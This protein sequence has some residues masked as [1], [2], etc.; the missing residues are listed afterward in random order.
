MKK[1]LREQVKQKYGNKCSYCGQVL[2]DKWQVDHATP[3]THWIWIQRSTTAKADDIE[4]LVPACR[5]CNHY[6]R[7]QPVESSG[8]WIGYREYMKSF[9]KRL[10]KLPKNTQVPSTQRRKEYMWC[11]ANKYG[12]TP[13]KPFSGVFHMDQY[14]ALT[15][16]NPAPITN[17]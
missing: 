11:I 6:K 2:D 7:A 17:L 5:I 4:N 13:D 1:A 8:G 3:K 9:H 16:T 10:G 15:T 12:I 14:N